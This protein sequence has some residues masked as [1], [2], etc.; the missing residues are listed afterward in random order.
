MLPFNLVLNRIDLLV[1]HSSAVY[2]TVLLW[3]DQEVAE[4]KSIAFLNPSG[5]RRIKAMRPKI[6]TSVF[7]RVYQNRLGRGLC[8]TFGTT[9]LSITGCPVRPDNMDNVI[10][11]ATTMVYSKFR[12]LEEYLNEIR[13]KGVPILMVLSENDKL[14]DTQISYEMA[15]ILGAKQDS[16]S[17]YNQYSVLEKE[18]KSHFLPWIVVLPEGGH[19]SFV[20]HPKVVNG[21][22][23]SFLEKL[24]ESSSNSCQ[25]K[26]TTQPKRLYPDVTALPVP[27]SR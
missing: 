10:L 16:F 25:E 13:E 6:V 18:R 1:S 17:V 19:Y 27:K 3:K 22:I 7:V 15:H 14:V 26:D 20:N 12:H 2:P 8:R 24:K 11:S 21:E 9:V 5:H 4:I 23:M